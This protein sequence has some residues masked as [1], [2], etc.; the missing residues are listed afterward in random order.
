MEVIIHLILV[1]IKIA[2]LG[3]IYATLALLTFKLIGRLRPNSWFDKV[4]KK[5]LRLWLV[6]GLLSSSA[7]LI[8]MFTYWGNHGLGDGPQIPISN[9]EIITNTNWEDVCYLNLPNDKR[10]GFEIEKYFVINNKLCGKI[11]TNSFYEYEYQF[12]IFDLITKKTQ[13]FK[14]ENQ[15]NLFAKTNGI[16]TADK[17]QRFRENYRSYWGGWRAWFLA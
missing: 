15:Y 2:I 4:S 3:S 7:L 1:L 13:E 17:L 6:G 10:Q 14:T 11:D 9:G 5:K 16:I 8:F 12:F